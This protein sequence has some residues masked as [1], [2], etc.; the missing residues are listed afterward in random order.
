M[1]S[2]Y[3]HNFLSNVANK[4]DKQVVQK[5]KQTDKWYW[6]H[7]FLCEGGN[8]KVAANIMHN[9]NRVAEAD[10]IISINIKSM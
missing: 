6:K 7:K 8:E 4:T 2:K 5:D 10:R 1:S 3:F 9:I